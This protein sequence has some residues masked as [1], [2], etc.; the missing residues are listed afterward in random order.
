MTNFRVGIIG[1]G[2]LWGTPGATG[3]GQGNVHAMGYIASPYC[4]LVAAADIKQDNLNAFCQQYG[5]PHGYLDY[6]EMLAKEQP[7]MISICLWPRLHGPVLFDAVKAGVKAIHCEKPIAPTWGE[8]Q[9]MVQVCAEKGVQL[10]FNHQRRFGRPFRKAKE[11]LDSGAIGQLLRLEGFTSNLYDWGTHWFDMMFFY[12]N[13]EPVEWVIGQIDARGGHKIFDVTVEGQGLSYW[14]WKNGVY[15]AM[16]TGALSED[17][18]GNRLIGSEGV[19]EVW[20]KNG[21]ALRMKNAETKGQWVEFDV[22]VPDAYIKTTVS[23]VVDAVEALHDGREPMLAGRK[24]LQATEIIF[25][26]YESSRKRGRIDLPLTIE[27]SPLQAML[28]AGTVSVADE[29]PLPG[30]AWTHG[31]VLA[32]RIKVHYYRTGGKKP[33]FVLLHGFSDNG[34]CWIR[35][36]Q[37]LESDYDLIMPDARGHGLSSAPTEGYDDDTRAADV[38]RMV[39]ALDVKKPAIM[40][41][42]MGAATTAAA[43]AAYPDLWGCAVLEDPPWFEADSPWAARMLNLSPEEQ[44]KQAAERRAE[45]EKRK[46]IPLAEIIAEGKKQTPTWDEV[47]WQPWAESKQQ[48]SPNAALRMGGPRAHWSEVVAKIKCPTLLII[49]SPDKHAIVTPATAHKAAQLNPLIEVV[50]L[51]AGHNIRREQFEGFVAAVRAFLSKHYH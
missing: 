27:D 22:G 28:D 37:A 15:G 14:K 1:C 48:L 20:A 25:A 36:A 16:Y 38:A 31:T 6:K 50:Q 10:T 23:A 19:I 49:G 11:L 34:L 44:E 39:M 2:R 46:T 35:A 18:C 30:T 8:A 51:D 4:D 3:M 41:H 13:E 26:T 24:A 7:D 33:P 29:K 47:E 42:S 45:I 40:G 17:G 9:R 43:I 5:I 21:P 12:N 32:N